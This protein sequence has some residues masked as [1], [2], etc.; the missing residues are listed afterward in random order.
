MQSFD[1]Y[2]RLT[3]P[4]TLPASIIPAV[5]G[6]SLSIYAEGIFRPL[7]A[8]LMVLCAALIQVA[9]NFFNE[10]F[11]YKNGLDT[12]ESVGIGGA[13]VREGIAPKTMLLAAFALYGISGLIGI[14]LA[15]NSSWWLLLIGAVCLVI[16]Y[17]YT[18]GPLPISRTPYGE[19]FAGFLFGSGFSLIAYFTQTGHI[20]LFAFA[21]GLPLVVL[22]GLLLTANSLRDRV[23]DKAHGR[24]TLAIL[25]GHE[26]TVLFMT[27]GFSF[28]YTWLIVLMTY[29]MNAW[30]L[31]P[32][33]SMLH[34][35]NCVNAFRY[36]KGKSPQKMMRGMMHCSK[37][38]QSFGS[39]YIIAILL[40]AAWQALLH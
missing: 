22:V 24:R 30:I 14:V 1:Y 18:G 35:I 20:T 11:D 36:S 21:A 26:R 9:T 3:R 33:F 31:L 23:A 4:H 37:T 38:L 25:L 7:L 40:Q 27:A 15:A 8:V 29:G 10:Y 34:A 12:E 39:L 32:V 16:G 6:I 13:I 17:C 5:C 2:W 19:L 28:C